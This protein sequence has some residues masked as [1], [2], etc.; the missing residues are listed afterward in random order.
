MAL[1]L[2]LSARRSSVLRRCAE[3]AVGTG[4]GDLE[5]LPGME[6]GTGNEEEAFGFGDRPISSD[7]LTLEGDEMSK[8]ASESDGK[9]GR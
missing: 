9:G 4:D 8:L 1:F 5:L 6:S 3:P 7:R 2:I